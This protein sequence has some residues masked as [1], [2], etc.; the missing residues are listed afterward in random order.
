[1]DETI[2]GTTTG[3]DTYDDVVMDKTEIASTVGPQWKNHAV[4]PLS[5]VCDQTDSIFRV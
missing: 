4:V 1:M 5:Q 2:L 3:K